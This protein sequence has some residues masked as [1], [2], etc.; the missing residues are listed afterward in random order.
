MDFG[1]WSK[2]IRLVWMCWCFWDVHFEGDSVSP[3]LKLCKEM[4]LPQQ[5]MGVIIKDSKMQANQLQW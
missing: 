3:R 4:A 5:P 2:E 1:L